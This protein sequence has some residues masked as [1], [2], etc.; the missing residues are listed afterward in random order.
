MPETFTAAN[1]LHIKVLPSLGALMDDIL[2]LVGTM[3][4]LDPEYPL[5]KLW[6][7]DLAFREA[8]NADAQAKY[9]LP[10]ASIEE[11]LSSEGQLYLWDNIRRVLAEDVEKIQERESGQLLGAIDHSLQWPLPF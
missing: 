1:R 11:R 5:L 8:A 4:S 3:L 7:P 6:H 2:D 9:G 10:G